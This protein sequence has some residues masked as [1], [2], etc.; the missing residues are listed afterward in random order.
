MYR[1]QNVFAYYAF[2]QYDS[3]LI[4]V[5][6]PRHVSYQQVLTQ[7]QFAISCRV[8]FCQDITFLNALTFRANRTQVDSHALVSLAE[9]RNRIF[10]QRR[11]KAYKLFIISTVV[12]NTDSS[13]IYEFNHTITFSRN[14][15]TRVF[16][17]LTFDTGTY[18]RSF[19]L[20]PSTH[21]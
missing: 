2:V 1:S 17:Q 10:F 14:L 5:T 9:L 18:D 7:C 8:T 19:C 11:F 4:V 3:I 21:G 6:L 13:S 12:K 16:A 20:I 15:S